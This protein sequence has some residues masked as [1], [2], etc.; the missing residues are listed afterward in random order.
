MQISI[1]PLIAQ[2]DQERADLTWMHP[3]RRMLNAGLLEKQTVMVSYPD[4]SGTFAGLRSRPDGNL[5]FHFDDTFD[6]Q[7]IGTQQPPA[8]QGSFKT[9]KDEADYNDAIFRAAWEQNRCASGSVSGIVGKI[10]QTS[11]LTVRWQG[12]FERRLRI[13]PSIAALHVSFQRGKTDVL[14]GTW[15]EANGANSSAIPIRME[16]HSAGSDIQQQ[17]YI[18]R[19]KGKAP[20]DVSGAELNIGRLIIENCEQLLLDSD[21]SARATCQTRVELTKS[22][23]IICGVDPLAQTVQPI[24]RKQPDGNWVVTNMPYTLPTFSIDATNR[25]QC[26]IQR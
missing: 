16:G 5:T 3:I 8:V 22:G 1:A 20:D 26:S 24:F 2:L 11:D 9:C 10:G 13:P 6:L 21:V 7:V 19:W 4:L 25:P 17:R 12:E 18:Y 14:A 15:V 23:E